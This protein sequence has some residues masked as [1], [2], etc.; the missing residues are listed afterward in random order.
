M[1][2]VQYKLIKLCHEYLSFYVNISKYIADIAQL[3][4]RPLSKHPRVKKGSTGE[5]TH[6]I[7]TYDFIESLTGK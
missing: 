4:V 7:L 2:S 3:V 5:L 6:A 1:N